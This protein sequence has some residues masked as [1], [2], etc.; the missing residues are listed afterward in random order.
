MDQL[1][2]QLDQDQTSN[3][4]ETRPVDTHPDVVSQKELS[5]LQEDRQRLQ[6]RLEVIHHLIKILQDFSHY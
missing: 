3:T 2:T 6:E 5:R 1:Q 4:A